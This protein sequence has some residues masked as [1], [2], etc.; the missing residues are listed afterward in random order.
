MQ[1]ESL[2]ATDIE[3]LAHGSVGLTELPRLQGDGPATL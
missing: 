2:C 1:P 3:R